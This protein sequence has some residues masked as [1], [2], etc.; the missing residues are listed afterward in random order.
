MTQLTDIERIALTG[1]QDRQRQVQV[2]QMALLR[3]VEDRLRLPIGSIGTTHQIDVQTWRVVH[4]GGP[5][6]EPV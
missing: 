4:N 3:A 2:D 6:D 5:G 1:I